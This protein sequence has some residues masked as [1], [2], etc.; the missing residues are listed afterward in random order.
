MLIR[1]LHNW[2]DEDCVRILRSI[3]AAMGAHSLLLLGEQ[4]LEPDPA[5]GRATGYLIDVQMMTMFGRARERSE[6][7]FRTMF[8]RSGFSLRR[9]IPTPSPIAI[10]E[11]APSAAPRSALRCRRSGGLD[12]A[13]LFCLKIWPV[14]KTEH[15]PENT[16]DG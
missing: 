14:M 16:I 2:S 10:I 1:V 5:R 7:E 4:I 13:A 3:R 12:A 15:R 9:V 11:A 8:D 6:V